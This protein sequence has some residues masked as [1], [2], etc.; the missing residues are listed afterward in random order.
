M[1]IQSD[2]WYDKAQICCVRVY[3]LVRTY[4]CLF[5][6]QFAMLYGVYPVGYSL[7]FLP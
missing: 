6:K 1:L 3:I 4:L 2:E 5:F 7:Y